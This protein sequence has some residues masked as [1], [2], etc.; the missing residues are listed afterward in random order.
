M[1]REGRRR[2]APPYPDQSAPK[3]I[4]RWKGDDDA[5]RAVYANRNRLL[6]G[7]A[8]QALKLRAEL[9]ERAFALTLDH[10]GMRRTW[11]R[12]RDNIQKRYFLHISGYNLG[13]IMRLLIGAGTPR[14]W[15]EANVSILWLHDRIDDQSE[16]LFC[17]AVLLDQ[18]K[19]SSILA[20]E[21]ICRC[22]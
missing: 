10:G 9:V 11:L 21:I 5:R 2:E 13:L 12:G 4:L 1:V 6:S 17:L 19:H 8:K 20:V 14:R 15:V 16:V 22:P 18:P 7:V 3:G